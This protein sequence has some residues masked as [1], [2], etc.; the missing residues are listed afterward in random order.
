VVAIDPVS[1]QIGNFLMTIFCGLLIGVLFDGYRVIRGILTPKT[2]ITGLGDLIFWFVSTLV[3]FATLLLTN[4]GEVRLY[5]FL[6]LAIGIFAYM[7]LCSR[8]ITRIIISFWRV[9][10]TVYRW[11]VKL[12][13][14]MVW[15]PLVWIMRLFATPFVWLYRK[16]GRYLI[17]RTRK[18]GAKCKAKVKPLLHPRDPPVGPPG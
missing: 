12:I 6:G 16:P 1:I 15:R 11:C 9:S 14:T 18:I 10:C 7:R 8:I 4:W 17:K 13:H 5:V 2:L 3:V